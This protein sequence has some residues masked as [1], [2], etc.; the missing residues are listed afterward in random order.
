MTNPTVKIT[1]VRA[2]IIGVVSL[3]VIGAAVTGVLLATAKELRYPTQAKLR[4]ALPAAA[5]AELKARGVGLSGALSCADLPGW[6]KKRL[7]VSCSGVTTSKK[8]VDVIGSGNQESA[9]H[10]FT[11]LVGGTPVVQNVPCLG[12]GCRHGG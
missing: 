2:A 12:R 7:R 5:A 9:D 10:Y 6:T 11:I 8:P 3:A 1:R 4:G